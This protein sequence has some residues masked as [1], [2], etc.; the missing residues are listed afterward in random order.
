MTQNHSYNTNQKD[1]KSSL[2]ILWLMTLVLQRLPFV[3]WT[4][5]GVLSTSLIITFRSS[6]YKSSSMFMAESESSS[7]N[8]GFGAIAQTFGVPG[9][10]GA[11]LGDNSNPPQF[12]T[13]VLGSYEFL[14]DIAQTEYHNPDTSENSTGPEAISPI[15]HFTDPELE[16]SERVSQTVDELRIRLNTDIDPFSNI[17]TVEVTSQW[18]WLSESINRSMLELLN[19][20][21]VRKR[22][23]RANLER[24]FIES[25]QAEA[26]R[27][28]EQAE[29]LL[30]D[31]YNRN[32]RMEDSPALLAEVA[33]LQRRVEVNQQVYLTLSQSYEQARIEEVRNTP[34][35]TVIDGPEGSAEPL[36][37]LI[38]QIV[39]GI[40]LGFGI[41]LGYILCAEFM[42]LQNIRGL[43][44]YLVFEKTLQQTW[45]FSKM[46]R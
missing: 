45:P 43:P 17:V 28:L 1:P 11:L 33:R 22:G 14:S 9:A 5:L 19:E 6:E 38:V 8:A 12:Y 7:S 40:L 2:S 25:R 42:R 13:A 46:N 16:L 21:N 31:F 34:L 3:S 10:A 35:I 27:D 44:E 29:D 32:R 24:V 36:W 18:K 20:T 23:T 30:A 39:L 15:D 37:S 41:A 4:I 26:Q